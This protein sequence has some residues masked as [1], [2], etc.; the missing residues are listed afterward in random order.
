MVAFSS[1]VSQCSLQ[2]ARK[3]ESAHDAVESASDVAESDSYAAEFACSAAESASDA[4]LLCWVTA[5]A[6]VVRGLA[7]ERAAILPFGQLPLSAHALFLA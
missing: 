4:M 1:D 6:P 7:S 2:G 3:A 5:S